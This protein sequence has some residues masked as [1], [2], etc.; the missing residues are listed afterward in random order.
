[1]DAPITISCSDCA[2]EHTDACAD[3]LVTFL[4]EREPDDAIVIDAAEL[5]AVRLL[6]RGGLV[7]KLRHEQHAS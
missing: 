6:A 1:M 3:C 5:R 7:P 4:V 2:L